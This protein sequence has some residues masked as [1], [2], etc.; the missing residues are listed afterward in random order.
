[1]EARVKK[2]LKIFC[3]T[4]EME[5][6]A[7]KSSVAHCNEE[8]LLILSVMKKTT[9]LRSI[10][11]N[12]I[13]V[14]NIWQLITTQKLYKLFGWIT[15]SMLQCKNGFTLLVLSALYL[16]RPM[17]LI[18]RSGRD[19]KQIWSIFSMVDSNP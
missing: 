6:L 14:S 12:N 8:E 1:M 9:A 13:G 3:D 7:L 4:N 11:T 19:S 2:L 10:V 15:L 18:V 16:R 17:L 5:I